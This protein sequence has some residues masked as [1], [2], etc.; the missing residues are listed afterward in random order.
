[1]KKNGKKINNT[2]FTYNYFLKLFRK[3]IK[4]KNKKSKFENEL[5]IQETRRI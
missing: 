2:I 4:R 5:L 1:M 3:N